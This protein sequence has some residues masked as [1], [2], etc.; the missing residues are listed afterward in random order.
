MFN[1]ESV[2]T[3]VIVSSIIF[4][5][6]LTLSVSGRVMAVEVPIESSQSNEMVSA[7][8][9]PSDLFVSQPT[10]AS[11]SW[12]QSLNLPALTSESTAP[13][14]PLFLTE[15]IAPKDGQIVT[16]Q[17]P[18]L[19]VP[20][21]MSG[22]SFSFI[23]ANSPTQ[24]GEESKYDESGTVQGSRQWQVNKVLTHGQTY[25][26]K[27]LDLTN[28]TASDWFRFTVDIHRVNWQPTDVVGPFTVGLASGELVANFAS[29]SV[30]SMADTMQLSLAYSSAE[31]GSSVISEGWQLAGLSSLGY[32]QALVEDI[33]SEGKAHSISL[34][35]MDEGTLRFT[36]GDNN[37]VWQVQTQANIAAGMLGSLWVNTDSG[38]TITSIIYTDIEGNVSEFD[39]QGYLKTQTKV[40]K[41]KNAVWSV[42]WFGGRLTSI[43]DPVS[44]RS[45]SFNYTNT[46]S[47]YRPVNGFVRPANGVLTRFINFDGSK[48]TLWYDGNGNV[49][50]MAQDNGALV[51]FAYDSANNLTS[52][53]TPAAADADAFSGLSNDRRY[54]IRYEA[55]TGKVASIQ[56][57]AATQGAAR[58]SHLYS[59]STNSDNSGSTTVTRLAGSKSVPLRAAYYDN[60]W[61]VIRSTDL[62]D[63]LTSEWVWDE[64][65]LLR[66][67][68]T[69]DNLQI[70]IDYNNLGLQSQ[71]VG[72]APV[73]KFDEAPVST[74][75]YDEGLAPLVV[76]GWND[77]AFTGAP[78]DIGLDGLSF[79]LTRLPEFVASSEGWSAIITTL[80]TVP[81]SGELTLQG[82]LSDATGSVHL[83]VSGAE[84]LDEHTQLLTEAE[85]G[86]AVSVTFVV[87]GTGNASG[88][89]QLQYTTEESHSGGWQEVN[90]AALAAGLGLV[91]SESHQEQLSAA[92]GMSTL[93]HVRQYQDPMLGNVSSVNNE[94]EI[95]SLMYSDV[96]GFGRMTRQTLASGLG[97]NFNYYGVESSGFCSGFDAQGSAG[98]LA[99]LTLDAA[100]GSSGALTMSYAYDASGVLVGERNSEGVMA[101][102]DY[103]ERHN[104]MSVTITQAEETVKTMDVYYNF[105]GS[106]QTILTDTQIGEESQR[107]QRLYQFDLFGHLTKTQDEWG[108]IASSDIDIEAQTITQQVS[109][110]PTVGA[111]WKVVLVTQVDD[112]G[113]VIEMRR[114]RDDGEAQ[115]LASAH[116]VAGKLNSVDYANGS[117]VTLT[118]DDYKRVDYS[119]WLL[120]NNGGMITDSRLFTPTGRVLEETMTGVDGKTARYQYAYNEQNR[121]RWSALS[122]SQ[123]ILGENGYQWTYD[124]NQGNAGKDG[125]VTQEEVLYPD[126]SKEQRNFSYHN[127][128][129]VTS[130]ASTVWSNADGSGEP[131]TDKSL[132]IGYDASG[133]AM[134]EVT[135]DDGARL[136]L[137]YDAQ[138]YLIQGSDSRGRVVNY[139]RNAMG[140]ILGKEVEVDG[141][142]TMELYSLLGWRLDENRAPLTQSI[143]LPGGVMMSIMSD[144][145]TQG[146]VYNAL[147]GNRLF[148]TDETGAV[149]TDLSLFSP[150]GER[151]SMPV[152]NI[153]GAPLQGFESGHGVETEAMVFDT[154]LMGARVYLPT[155]HSFTTLDPQLNGGSSPYSYANGEPVNLHDP[156]GN[157][158]S[159]KNSNADP[160][161]GTGKGNFW[162]VKNPYMWVLAVATV[163][164]VAAGGKGVGVTRSII[165]GVI[166]SPLIAGALVAGVSYLQGEHSKDKLGKM[167]AITFGY[168]AGGFIAGYLIGAVIR[169]LLTRKN[170]NGGSERRDSNGTNSTSSSPR[171]NS[172][173]EQYPELKNQNMRYNSV[174][175][176][177]SSTGY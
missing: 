71:V 155:L 20:S 116:Y 15:K 110:Q 29:S 158:A 102:Y 164:G 14:S 92:E 160:S 3:R 30:Y 145:Q 85:Q 94:G 40:G 105:V 82:S 52:V 60:A 56:S 118:R 16:S 89:L 112:A 2:I 28:G 132:Q 70:Q 46:G 127:A 108:S 63:N 87:S 47:D 138:K 135:R 120:P 32:V 86:E 37:T 156:D 64:K 49:A 175:L 122:G 57:P 62:V 123:A 11:V 68:R 54:E 41:L 9:T 153:D 34:K 96:E 173:F 129:G 51:D 24:T 91:S 139:T 93:S 66:E 117:N 17:R 174:V 53:R 176:K 65:D 22:S 154:L 140:D 72:P 134:T 168:A 99:S 128:D 151:L 161:S 75:H 121:L 8:L 80:L 45:A 162:N 146:W 101:C 149:A 18:L 136:S 5:M 77:P 58:L 36:L 157:K 35:T 133:Y 21:E 171:N 25:F 143:Q 78:Q 26:W 23:V 148:V 97:T 48:V 113:R 126:G 31:H 12:T 76:R 124:F 90:E 1:P 83:V 159:R 107:S 147:Q 33:D 81:Q 44:G 142:V 141:S 61:R 172:V 125:A 67:V 74:R 69:G 130:V 150:Y 50:R 39:E 167:F 177:G 163:V 95:L 59:Y 103:D 42:G 131:Q 43:T 170:V 109:G 137:R 6:V 169:K 4:T 144:E 114:S 106:E 38:N 165:F 10:G 119:Q 152:S 115:T 88:Q 166:I 7:S 27:V 100:S 55:E 84:Q 79:D 73:S 98:Q 13:S 19:T 104:L 111:D